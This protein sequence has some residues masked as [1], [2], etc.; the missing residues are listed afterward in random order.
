MIKILNFILFVDYDFFSSKEE[1]QGEYESNPKKRRKKKEQLKA[2]Q[3]VLYLQQPPTF[4]LPGLPT[5]S[6]SPFLGCLSPSAESMSLFLISLREKK[7]R[8]QGQE[9]AGEREGGGKMLRCE[10]DERALHID[11][12]LCAGLHERNLEL[13]GELLA[14]FQINY[15]IPQVQEGM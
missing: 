1:K 4:G 8:R 11:V 5:R 12:S 13:A 6:T 9:S 15:L 7:T 10:C 3:L 14:L 2:R